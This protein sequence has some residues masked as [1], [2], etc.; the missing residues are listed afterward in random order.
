MPAV[1]TIITVRIISTQSTFAATVGQLRRPTVQSIISDPRQRKRIGSGLTILMLL[2]LLKVPATTGFLC[3]RLQIL[4]EHA[5]GL[6][7]LRF[8]RAGWPWFTN[9][10]YKLCGASTI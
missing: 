1:R 9:A 4:T 3:M 10:L 8:Q 2:T 7:P 6:F 5:P